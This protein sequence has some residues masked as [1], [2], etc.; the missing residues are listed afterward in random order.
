MGDK[1]LHFLTLNQAVQDVGRM[2]PLR[3]YDVPLALGRI[4]FR[5]VGLKTYAR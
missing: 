5:R 3:G 2:P 1:F 4:V